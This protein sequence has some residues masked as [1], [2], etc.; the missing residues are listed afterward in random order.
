LRTGDVSALALA[1]DHLRSELEQVA[2]GMDRAD[3]LS[4]LG[5]ALGELGDPE[6]VAALAECVG[7][8]RQLG[9]HGG[10][11]A[12]LGSLAE[13][14]LRR[15]DVANA[16]AHQLECL[17]LAAELA[18]PVAIANSFILAARIA[19]PMGSGDAAL[20]LHALADVMLDEA[21]FA[22][23]PS[24]QA[25]S[26]EMHERLRGELGEEQ[27]A[28]VIAAGRQLDLHAAMELAEHVFADAMKRTSIA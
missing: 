20:A 10:L 1:V 13:H 24:D 5:E 2:T 11:C 27:C 7:I 9:D 19:E 15:G 14:E 25:L 3:I 17:R 18:T 6:C 26:D 4:N 23:M 12:S 22:L 16:A 21:G 28:A 8:S